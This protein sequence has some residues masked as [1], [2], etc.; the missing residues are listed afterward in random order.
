MGYL[1]RIGVEQTT[2]GGEPAPETGFGFFTFPEI[3]HRRPLAHLLLSLPALLL[4][5]RP[6]LKACQFLGARGFLVWRAMQSQ[7]EILEA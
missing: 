4:P 7:G 6:S 3:G 2:E 1:T 5:L